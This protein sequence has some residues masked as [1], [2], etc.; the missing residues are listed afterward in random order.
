[1]D[2]WD[3]KNLD[4]PKPGGFGQ[5]NLTGGTEMGRDCFG[6]GAERR[7]FPNDIATSRTIF[8]QCSTRSGTAIHITMRT[9]G[10]WQMRRS[11]YELDGQ[12]ID[13]AKAAIRCGALGLFAVD[14]G[15]GIVQ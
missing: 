7:V 13:E 11:F 10:F 6:G 3:G 9:A 14:Y 12:G 8:E 15:L 5:L 2:D 4:W 1:M